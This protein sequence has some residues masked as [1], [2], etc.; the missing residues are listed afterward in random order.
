MILRCLLLKEFLFFIL[1]SVNFQDKHLF[2]RDDLKSYYDQ[3]F[4]IK[5]IVLIQNS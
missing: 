4:F 1:F 3:K 5:S 2:Q